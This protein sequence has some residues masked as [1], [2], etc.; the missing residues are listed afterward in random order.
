MTGADHLTGEAGESVARAA[1]GQCV[2]EARG[3]RLRPDAPP[4]DFSLRTGELVGL[5]GLEG[6]GQ[7]AFLRSLRGAGAYQ[8]EVVRLTDGEARVIRSPRHAAACGVAYLPRERRAE[9]IFESLSVRENFALPTLRRDTRAGILRPRRSQ[10]RLAEYVDGL[11]VTLASVRDRIAALSGGNQQKIVLARWLAAHPRV[12]LLNDP[13]RGVDAGTKHDI[14][15][16]LARLTGE[17]LAVVMLSTELDELVELMDR[18]LVF[19]EQG[20]FAE[21]SRA[22]ATREALVAA[23]FGQESRG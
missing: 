9:S 8:G 18:V 14:Y 19:R 10:R 23:F 6:Q 11:G 20:L 15:D 7:D 22:A 12:L 21:L 3:L 5:A 4:V 2:L 17:G 1:P 13:T 16:L